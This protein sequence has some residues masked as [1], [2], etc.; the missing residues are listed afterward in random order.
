MEARVYRHEID[1]E[2][3]NTEISKLNASLLEARLEETQIEEGV[4][5]LDAVLG[6]AARVLCNPDRLWE[7]ASPEDKLRFQEA[8]F[9]EGLPFDGSNFGTA[10]TCLILSHLQLQTVQNKKVASPTGFEPVPPA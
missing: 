3:F 8:L 7:S 9:P 2:T 10:R 5:D 1:K 4:L 6:F